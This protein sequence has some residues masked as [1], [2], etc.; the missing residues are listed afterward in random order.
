MTNK[1]QIIIAGAGPVGCVVG[2]ILARA[3]ISVTILETENDLIPELRASTFHPPTLD[4]LDDLGVTPKLIDQ[5]LITP[6][7]QYRDLEDGLVAEFDHALI[8][9]RTKHPYRLQCEQFKLTRI[10]AEMLKEFPHAEISFDSKFVDASQTDNAVRVFY[11]TP[12]GSEQVTCDYLI[13]ADGSRSEVRKSQKIEFQGFT[14]PE[15]FVT[16]SVPEDVD[17]IVPGMGHVCYIAH[18]TQWCALIHAPDYWRFLFPIPM[19]TTKEEAFDDDFLEGRLQHL[20]PHQERYA[21]QLRTLYGVNQRVAETYRSGRILLAGDSAHVNNPLGGMGMNGGIHDGVNL[22]DK[23]VRMY[24]GGETEEL[25]NLYDRQRRPI[26]IEYVQAQTMRNKKNLEETDPNVRRQRQDEL[27]DVAN[28][29]EKSRELLL[30][31][32][33]I[34]GLERSEAIT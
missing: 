9:D 6:K 3:G 7:I 26:A 25:L 13:G 32:S 15:Q 17:K 5:G 14:Y 30:Q 31:T 8:D 20:A 21:I 24:G 12:A 4:M 16:V 1:T 22:A 2:L 11:E 34:N 23:L 29:V 18:P 19:E 28:N 27:R 33:M 10:I